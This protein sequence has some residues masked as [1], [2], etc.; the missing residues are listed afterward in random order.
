L[1]GN[2]IA[3]ALPPLDSS[4]LAYYA[5][6]VYGVVKVAAKGYERLSDFLD[7]RKR[8]KADEMAHLTE[9]TIRTRAEAE[10]LIDIQGKTIARY[11]KDIA[12]ASRRELEAEGRAKE[13]EAKAKELDAKLATAGR[14]WFEREGVIDELA[15]RLKKLEDA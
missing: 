8:G 6:L 15:R 12:A 10:H 7:K 3:S 14:Q 1:T 11:E 9:E 5:V 2:L 13:W 4:T